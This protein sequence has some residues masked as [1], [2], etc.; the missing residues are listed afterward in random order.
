M[1]TTITIIIHTIIIHINHY[2][3]LILS[4]MYSV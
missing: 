3:Y 4:W 1:S 2:H